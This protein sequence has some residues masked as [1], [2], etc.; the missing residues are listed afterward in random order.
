MERNKKKFMKNP[1]SE[2]ILKEESEQSPNTKQENSTK[3]WF[4]FPNEFIWLILPFFR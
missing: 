1:Q 4:D 2:Q 3:G